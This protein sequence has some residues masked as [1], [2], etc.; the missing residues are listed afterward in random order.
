MV[1]LDNQYPASK[2]TQGLADAHAGSGFSP[3]QL[4]GGIGGKNTG[5]YQQQLYSSLEGLLPEYFG[6]ARQGSEKQRE[7]ISGGFGRA[8]GLVNEQANEAFQ[9]NA[10]NLESAFGNIRSGLASSG[11][12]GSSIEGQLALGA[13]RQSADTEINTRARLAGI[14]ADLEI[15]ETQAQLGVDQFQNDLVLQELQQLL[16]LGLGRIGA[17]NASIGLALQGRA[18]SLAENQFGTAQ[19]LDSFGAVTSGLGNFL[20]GYNSGKD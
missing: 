15:G 3:D 5:V 10:R 8:K 16:G 7:T 17:G 12:S 13:S 9:T 20:T 2:V 11:F 4:L 19:Y 6:R 1:Q 14:L 18:Q